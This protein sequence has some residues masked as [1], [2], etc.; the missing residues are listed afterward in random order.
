MGGLFQEI[1]KNHS[2]YLTNSSPRK[3]SSSFQ[4]R[5]PFSPV[6]SPGIFDTQVQPFPSPLLA[7]QGLAFNPGL[8]GAVL[9]G[10]LLPSLG[11]AVSFRP[12]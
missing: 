5:P 4:P 11:S 8:I 3:S 9:H 2:C 6:H 10:T 1:S 7:A 12:N